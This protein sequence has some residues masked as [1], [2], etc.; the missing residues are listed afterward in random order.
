MAN[1]YHAH[2]VLIKRFKLEVGKQIPNIRIFDNTVGLFYTKN[3]TPVKIGV[4]GM[5]DCV[6]YYKTGNGIMM[7]SFE[8]KT[9]KAIQSKD[10]KMW[11]EFIVS[12]G[13]LYLIVREDI[14]KSI[15]SI[16][17]YLTEKGITV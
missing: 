7:L 3:R 14:Q 10:Q 1:R 13:G 2:Q 4:N 5:S 9:G 12:Y 17:S 6:G 15:D 8:F 11:E 16:K